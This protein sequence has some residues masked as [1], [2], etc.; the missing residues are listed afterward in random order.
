MTG[1]SRTYLATVD[2]YGLDAST[3]T[4]EPGVTYGDLA[5]IGDA[6][7]TPGDPSPAGRSADGDLVYVERPDRTTVSLSRAEAARIAALLGGALGA[8]ESPVPPHSDDAMLL[9]AFL[10]AAVPPV[11][12]GSSAHEARRLR[13]AQRACLAG[14]PAAPG[15][16]RH[17]RP[18]GPS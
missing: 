2:D 4:S 1:S 14:N 7:L 3:P 13:E 10:D 12:Y 5:P 17:L 15:W 16:P 8:T 18:S 9:K 6:I 11:F